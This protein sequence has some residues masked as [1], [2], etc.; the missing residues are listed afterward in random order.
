MISY[1]LS[2]Y[3]QPLY[4][5]GLNTPITTEPTMRLALG[6]MLI[7]I[8]LLNLFNSTFMFKEVSNEKRREYYSLKR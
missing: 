8:C 5:N 6:I 2:N 7:L 4:I 3:A 1:L